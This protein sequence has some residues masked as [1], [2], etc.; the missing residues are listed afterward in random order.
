MGRRRK[1]GW[2][3]SLL[4]LC[5]LYPVSVLPAQATTSAPLFT[6]SHY[7]NNLTGNS[8]TDTGY[9]SRQ[10]Q[11]DAATGR[12]GIVVLDFGAET[13]PPYPTADWTH[14]STK[15]R[16]G[17]TWSFSYDLSIAE[18]YVKGWYGSSTSSQSL[19]IGM[20]TNNSGFVDSTGG[21]AWADLS[22]NFANFITQNNYTSRVAAKSADDLEVD[23]SPESNGVSWM[24]GYSNEYAAYASVPAIYDHGDAAGC[25]TSGTNASTGDAACQGQYNTWHQS[26]LY[27]V[28][29]GLAASYAL[30][31]MYTTNGQQAQQWQQISL[32][33]YINKG[34]AIGFALSGA[35]TQS[36]ACTDRGCPTGTNNTADQGWTQ[37]YNA[38][39]CIS[40]AYATCNTTSA[41]G[42]SVDIK[43]N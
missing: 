20:G 33:G 28:A 8:D 30:P 36:Q 35:L 7:V 31:Q 21:T 37:L 4:T 11:T 10:G 16:S 13:Q 1:S 5:L 42:Y 43:W 9:W 24:Q 6:T 38:V 32:W 14:W 41:V 26:T 15:D 25:P 2:L 23:W 29:Y 19:L 17:Y 22:G 12:S 3:V 18:A 39:N 40:P 34:N 27:Q